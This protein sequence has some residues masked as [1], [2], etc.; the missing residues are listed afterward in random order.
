M[1]IKHII[2]NGGGPSGLISYG[3][4]R[5]LHDKEFWNI[6]NIKSMYGTSIGALCCVF[7]SLKYDMKYLDDY[8]IKRPWDKV[9][10]KINIDDVLNIF[11]M[12]GITNIE[13]FVSNT[14]KL[15]FEAL[16][17]NFDEITMEEYYNY[18]KIELHF[19][20]SEI[21]NFKKVD[22][23]YKSHGNL[24]LK[25]ALCM[26]AA[27]PILFKPIYIN[28]E[29]YIDGGLFVN[30]PLIE[31]IE[32]QKCEL[33][34]IIGIKDSYSI[35]NKLKEESSFIEYLQIIIFKSLQ[36]IRNEDK[37]IN[38]PYQINSSTDIC[39]D[40]NKWYDIIVK[41]EYRE[42]I[43]NYGIEQGKIF[44]EKIIIPE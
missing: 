5:Y 35:Y 26:S 12:Q 27:Y 39:S 40:Y 37:L 2:I 10:N 21:N 29:C 6:E 31:C 4:L 9:H 3:I 20:T 18:C 25:D 11:N 16:N 13:K 15:L 8:I 1:T 30:Y 34:E 24:K 7:F 32:E 17:L 19:F 42:S 28:D 22:L 23:S 43:I 41:R 14:F 33:N 36:Y 38:I 44:Y